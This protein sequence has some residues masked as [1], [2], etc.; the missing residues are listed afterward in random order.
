LE[1]FRYAMRAMPPIHIIVENS[2]VTL[3]GAVASQF[4]SQLGYTAASQVS[5]IFEVRNELKV[6]D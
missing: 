5:G 2:R 1:L 4:D 3:K 6:D